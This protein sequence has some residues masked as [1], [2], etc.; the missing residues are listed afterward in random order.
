MNWFRQALANDQAEIDAPAAPSLKGFRWLFAG[1]LFSFVFDY[2]SPELE[3]GAVATGGSVFQFA[4]LGLA[5]ATGG[6]AT[7]LGW[8]H[9]LVRPGV[10]PVIL[11]WGYVVMARSSVEMKRVGS[12]VSRFRSSS[13]DS[14]STP[15]SSSPRAGC[16]RV[17]RCDGSLPLR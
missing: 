13:S 4:F 17:R 1:F 7:L 12:C 6:L 16:G 15:P 5:M 9:L 8:K 3:F 2:K 10:Y 14:T 11:W